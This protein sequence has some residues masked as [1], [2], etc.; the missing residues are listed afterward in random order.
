M[1]GKDDVY[2]L[3]LRTNS[4]KIDTLLIPYRDGSTQ[5]I[6]EPV[7]VIA[8]LAALFPRLRVGLTRYQGVFAPN[9]R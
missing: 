7:D 4:Y 9:S 6:F 5:V 1:V 3:L 2:Y 8:K